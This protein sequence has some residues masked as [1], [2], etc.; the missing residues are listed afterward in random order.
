MD[1]TGLDLTGLW[2]GLDWIE[3]ESTGLHFVVSLNN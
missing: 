3:L 2:T 1:K